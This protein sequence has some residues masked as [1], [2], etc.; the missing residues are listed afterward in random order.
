MKLNYL[1]KVFIFDRGLKE[2][3]HRDLVSFQLTQKNGF[4]LTETEKNG[5]VL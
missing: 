4:V 3:G 5:P 2:Q 1:L